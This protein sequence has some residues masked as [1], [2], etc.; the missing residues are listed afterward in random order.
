MAGISLIFLLLIMVPGANAKPQNSGAPKEEVEKPLLQTGT[1]GYCGSSGTLCN[2]WGEINASLQPIGIRSYIAVGDPTIRDGLWSFMRVGIAGYPTQGGWHVLESGWLKDPCF[3]TP[4]C[5]RYGSWKLETRHVVIVQNY[6]GYSKMDVANAPPGQTHEYRVEKDASG[7]GHLAYIDSNLVAGA[8]LDFVVPALTIGGGEVQNPPNNG[9]GP[10]TFSQVKYK[11][12]S[13]Q[14]VN[15]G[16]NYGMVI[17]TPNTSYQ[18][19]SYGSN[20]WF[21]GGCN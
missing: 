10:S 2:A 21:I 17:T 20:S 11:N 16:T 18:A 15:V 19:T 8:W 12:T 5:S 13:H 3:V 14:W 4:G 6:N 7:P 1:C 9:L